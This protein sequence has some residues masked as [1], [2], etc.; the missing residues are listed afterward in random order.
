MFRTITG[1]ENQTR[2][3]SYEGPEKPIL[4]ERVR[5]IF[6][7]KRLEMAEVYRKHLRDA[8]H[9]LDHESAQKMVLEFGEH[10]PEFVLERF[11]TLEQ[12]QHQW[13]Q[14]IAAT[15]LRTELK[16]STDSARAMVTV[17][18]NGS[19]S[20]EQ[21]EVNVGW[22]LQPEFTNIKIIEQLSPAETVEFEVTSKFQYLNLTGA[23]VFITSLK[24]GDRVFGPEPENDV[25]ERQLRRWTYTE[26]GWADSVII[27]NQILVQ[28]QKIKCA[29]WDRPIDVD[30]SFGPSGVQRRLEIEENHS[31]TVTE[32]LRSG[33][34]RIRIKDPGIPR[35]LRFP[36]YPDHKLH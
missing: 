1:E 34:K 6:D 2:F 19:E 27:M 26:D 25:F 9:R 30:V 33:L 31:A 12:A 29:G 21:I 32:C 5:D 24:V 18:N 20:L 17:T 11:T 35:R 14:D 15:G 22:P 28:S 10:L 7:K 16:V 3:S 23:K 13:K 4:R 8:R 36:L